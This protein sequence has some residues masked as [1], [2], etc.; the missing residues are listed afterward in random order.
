[1]ASK[2]RG[3]NQRLICIAILMLFLVFETTQAGIS[4]YI[5]R[6]FAADQMGLD[7]KNDI[8]LIKN[9]K[10]NDVFNNPA[11]F[12]QTTTPLAATLNRVELTWQAFNHEERYSLRVTSGNLKI[13]KNP[14]VSL[15]NL[16]GIISKASDTFEVSLKCTGLVQ[17][18]V[19]IHFA[20]NYTNYMKTTGRSLEFTLEF[21]LSKHCDRSEKSLKKGANESSNQKPVDRTL[22]VTVSAVLAFLVCVILAVVFFWRY[23]K[24]IRK[25]FSFDEGLERLASPRESFGSSSISI[26]VPSQVPTVVYS[27]KKHTSGQFCTKV[28]KCD[29]K[30][31]ETTIQGHSCETRVVTSSQQDLSNVP[32]RPFSFNRQSSSKESKLFTQIS[33]PEDEVFISDET[34]VALAQ[35]QDEHNET[36]SLAKDASDSQLAFATLNEYWSE[37]LGES[38]KSRD[39]VEIR[40]EVLGQGTFGRVM[41]GKLIVACK[42]TEADVDLAVKICQ[43]DVDF[44]QMIAFVNEAILMKKLSHENLLNLLGVVLQVGSSPL[45]LTSYMQHG[46]LHKFLRHSRGIGIRRQLIG[47][48]QLV[49]FGS[50]IARGME[51]LA[52]QKIVHRDLAARNC[53]VDGN[54]NIKIGDFGL[55]RELKQFSLHKMEQ[56]T[57]LAVKWLAL[58]SLLYYIFTEKSDVWSFGIV[59]WELVT[60]GSQPYAG[61]DNYEVMPYLETGKR[62]PRPLRCPD[63]LYSIM[64]SCWLPTPEERPTFSVLVHKLEDYEL[65]LRPSCITFEFDED[66]IEMSDGLF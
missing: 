39:H 1:M 10:R 8:F 7:T 37:K 33:I 57:Q 4:L 17:G 2:T 59:L 34:D 19:D 15:P 64:Q 51:Y 49:N 46:D 21:V 45:I 22:V 40:S 48:K 58:E 32:Y 9:G 18:L 24:R 53:L 16:K 11:L 12:R 61:L 30:P 25:K 63:D 31:R 36:L 27:P 14:T 50:Q 60:L 5:H 6:T 13:M 35:S 41:R 47:S 28:A 52:S 20:L 62:L 43:E 65:R 26:P 56:P 29:E 3:K 66:T 44:D 55:A 42:A 23:V 38:V 54:L